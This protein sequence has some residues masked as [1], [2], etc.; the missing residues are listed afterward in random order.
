MKLIY[1]GR[2]QGLGFIEKILKVKAPKTKSNYKLLSTHSLCII[3]KNE[4]FMIIVLK[5]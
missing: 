5:L 4:I 2:Q 1:I 3:N